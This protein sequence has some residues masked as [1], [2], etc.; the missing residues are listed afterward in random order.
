MDVSTRAGLSRP[1]PWTEIYRRINSIVEEFVDL[2]GGKW[3]GFDAAFRLDQDSLSNI[4]R[5]AASLEAYT[6][7]LKGVFQQLMD[8][9]AGE[10]EEPHSGSALVSLCSVHAWYREHENCTLCRQMEHRGCWSIKAV[11]ATVLEDKSVPG[12]HILHCYQ[13]RNYQSF[14]ID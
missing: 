6:Q 9:N 12:M 8:R 11:Y 1:Q 2:R 13:A 3:N 10:L 7:N 5:K 4:K 14:P